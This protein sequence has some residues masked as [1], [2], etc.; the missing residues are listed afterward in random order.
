MAVS[1]WDKTTCSG[2]CAADPVPQPPAGNEK[3]PE[4]IKQNEKTNPDGSRD[5][6]NTE[7]YHNDSDGTTY[8]KETTTHYDPSGNQTGQSTSV[9]RESTKPSETYGPIGSPGNPGPYN[10]GQFDIPGRF[11]TFM[12]RVQSSGLFSFSSSFF[13]SLPGGGSPSITIEGG[14]TFGTHTVNLSESMGSG[15]AVLKTILLVLFG[16]LSIRAIIMKR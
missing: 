12:G 7:T 8:T 1:S 6:T 4:E 5:V 15:M 9:T 14:E 3:P 16:F 13:N 10:P 11:S 2:T